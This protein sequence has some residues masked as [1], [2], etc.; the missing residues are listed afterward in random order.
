M[1]QGF[2]YYNLIKVNSLTY[3]TR[4]RFSVLSLL[5]LCECIISCMLLTKSNVNIVVIILSHQVRLGQIE[6]CLDNPNQFCYIFG[7]LILSDIREKNIFLL[8]VIFLRPGKI[9]IN[10]KIFSYM[11]STWGTRHIWIRIIF[12]LIFRI[13]YIH[14]PY[15][16]DLTNTYWCFP[17]RASTWGVWRKQASIQAWSTWCFLPPP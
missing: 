2:I 17:P 5:P 13:L 15:G 1:K 4:K 8:I 16:Y 10:N 9:I 14:N 6:S 3:L 12:W 7:E 11:S